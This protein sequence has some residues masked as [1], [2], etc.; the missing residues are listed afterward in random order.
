MDT[1]ITLEK[2]D[3]VRERTQASYSHCYRALERASGDVVAAVVD[4]EQHRDWRRRLWNSRGPVASTIRGV[5]E[6]T[7]RTTIAVRNGERTVLEVPGLVGAATTVVLPMVAAA[8][9]L[10]ALF[11]HSTISFERKNP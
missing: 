7:Q 4:L 8:G 11:T 9:V 6:E 2:I 10:A 5:A 1:T 3:A